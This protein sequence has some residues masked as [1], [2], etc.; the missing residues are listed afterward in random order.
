LQLVIFDFDGTLI[1]SVPDLTASIN[2]M[3]SIYGLNEVKEELVANWLGDGAKKLVERALNY[4]DLDYNE[5]ALKIFKSHYSKNYAINTT[6]YPFAKEILEYLN[7]KYK[8]ALVTNKPYEFVKPILKKLEIDYFDLVLGGDSLKEKKPS[9]AP[10]F[11][12]CNKLKI[13]PDKAIIIGDSKNDILAGKNANIKTVAITH[14]YN[15]G[16]DIRKYLPD[17]VINSLKELKDIL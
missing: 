5:K 2:Y 7:K 15:F 14:G 11:Y 10:L 12:V 13:S 16:E 1:N 8:L 3:Y 9:P 17:I 6:L 4:Y